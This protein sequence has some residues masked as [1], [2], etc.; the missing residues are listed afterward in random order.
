MNKLCVCASAR[1]SVDGV[2]GSLVVGFSCALDDF[3]AERVAVCCNCWGA[4]HEQ[5]RLKI[6]TCCRTLFGNDWDPWQ[7][8][9]A[10]ASGRSGGIEEFDELHNHTMAE[11]RSCTFRAS[12][13]AE[14][15][16]DDVI[17]MSEV[18]ACDQGTADEAECFSPAADHYL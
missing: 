5:L 10:C 1:W 11:A 15:S 6:C 4:E 7:A 3:S 12:V 17:T 8:C 9:T 14:I 13:L 2:G 16:Q 18:K